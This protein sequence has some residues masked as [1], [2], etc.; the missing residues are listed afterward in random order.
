MFH[1]ATR[2]CECIA[3][4]LRL[5]AYCRQIKG[6]RGSARTLF[7]VSPFI[8]MLGITIHVYVNMGA[9][10]GLLLAATSLAVGVPLWQLTVLVCTQVGHKLA[11]R[12]H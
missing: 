11:V 9:T 10:M 1:P 3:V 4:S 5:R 8:F 2:S 7:F 6:F 12:L